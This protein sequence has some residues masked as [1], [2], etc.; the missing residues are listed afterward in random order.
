MLDKAG[1][2]SAKDL[3]PPFDTKHLDRLMEQ[4]D[5]DAL[6]VTSKHNIHY[7]MG[8]YNFFFFAVMDA[9]GVGRYLPALVY[10]R[11][12]PELTAYVGNGMENYEKELGRLW[13]PHLAL[14]I[15]DGKETMAEAVAHLEKI[16]GCRSIGIETSFLPADAAQTLKDGLGNCKFADASFV[17]ERL[18]AVK[19]PEELAILEEASNRVVDS[20]LTAIAAHGVGST[21][22]E[23]VDTLRLQ[24]QTRGLT[25]EYCLITA[26]TSHNRAPSDQVIQA[27]DPV[28]IDSGGN[29]KG[30]IGD[31]C[32]MAVAGEPD[33]E[34]KELLAEIEDVQQAA[35]K[36]IRAGAI[37]REIFAA[38]EGA[39]A[40]MPNK[41]CTVFVAHGMGLISHEAPRLT[42]SGPVPYPAE[43]EDKPLQAG[44]VISIETT[45]HHP[46]RGFIKLEDTVCVT[47]A[48]WKGFGDHGRG[49]NR[50]AQ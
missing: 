5:L 13:T 7:L 30:Y 31:V 9:I 2:G 39:L 17:L 33:S 25:F 20:M 18:R 36:P 14:K 22:R 34:L 50:F 1:N 24:E 27:G 23:I 48:G 3:K 35:R 8:G 28:S 41:S 21:K 47:E 44:Y 15:W 19:T 38:G 40:R 11:G 46:R 12:R 16:G 4:A 43:D 10:R 6:V 26:G 32:R 49:W 37:G 42:G 45:M 29:Y